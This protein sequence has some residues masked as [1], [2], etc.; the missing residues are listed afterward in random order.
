MIKYAISWLH[1][2][3]V[4]H[5]LW[6]CWLLGSSAELIISST[7]LGPFLL[8]LL[9]MIIGMVQ[10]ATSSQA[11]FANWLPA[12]L[13]LAHVK[14]WLIGWVEGKEK[15]GHFTT[16]NILMIQ[17]CASANMQVTWDPQQRIIATSGNSRLMN[18]KRLLK[19]PPIWWDALGE[20]FMEVLID[21]VLEE[22]MSIFL[23][24]LLRTDI[25]GRQKRRW[26][27]METQSCMVCLQ[28]GLTY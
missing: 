25:P 11:P 3:R 1:S 10:P 2:N 20:R 26:A 28:I 27:V 12:R 7:I 5:S 15:P 4:S 22:Y 9:C 16:F 23:A 18:A 24:D 17:I 21:W 6:S 13:G 8:V 14:P 19:L